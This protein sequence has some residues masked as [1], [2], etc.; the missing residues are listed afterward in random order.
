MPTSRGPDMNKRDRFATEICMTAADSHVETAGG[1][2]N[3][4]QPAQSSSAQLS[5]QQM[6]A[7]IDFQQAGER[8]HSLIADLY[9]ICR[10]ITGEGFRETL[11]KIRNAIPLEIREVPTGTQVFDW[12]IPREWNIRDA[13]VKSPTG[14]KIIDFSRSNLHVVNYSVP[15]HR[16]LSLWNSEGICTH[17]PSDPIGFRIAPRTTRSREVCLPTVS[18]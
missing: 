14:E 5:L 12:T 1:D 4:N 3:R 13:W 10:S 7:G 2:T 8:M 17:F 18:F 16:R 6:I 11:R 9:P 15:V